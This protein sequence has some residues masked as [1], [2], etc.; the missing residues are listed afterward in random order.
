MHVI[1]PMCP[2]GLI[3]AITPPVEHEDEYDLFRLEGR[4]LGLRHRGRDSFATNLYVPEKKPKTYGGQNSQYP[5]S[6]P[7]R[8]FTKSR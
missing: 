5:A 7:Q 8:M 4:L 6:R 3:R 1:V 2:I